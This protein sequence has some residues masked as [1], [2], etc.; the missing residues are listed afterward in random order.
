MELPGQLIE[1][2]DAPSRA[3]AEELAAELLSVFMPRW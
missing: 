2:R 3:N 1:T